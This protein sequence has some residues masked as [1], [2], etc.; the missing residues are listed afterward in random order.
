MSSAASA[1]APDHAPHARTGLLLA[2]LSA[3]GACYSLLQ[4]LVAPALPT[5]QHDLGVSTTA[6]AWIFTAYLLS[7]SI[8]TPIA[9]RLG[10]MFGK[11]KVFIVAVAALGVGSLIAA[12]SSSLGPMIAGR[13]IQ[14]IGGAVFPLS[15]AI[16]R[17]EFPR[18]KVAGGIAI[19]SAIL[20]IGGGLGIVLSGPIL[21]VLSYHWL[22]WIP[23][24]V[25]CLA[26]VAVI[27]VVPESKHRSGGTVNWLGAALLSGWL[28]CLLLGVSQGRTW[29]WASGR[30]IGLFVA[31]AV[32]AATWIK[33]E[34]RS[35]VPLVDMR[36]MRRR[37]V[38]TTNLATMLIGFGMFASFLLVPQFVEIPTSTGYGFGASVTQAGLFLVPTT[39]AMLIVSPF[40]GRITNRFGS[41]VPLVTGAVVSCAAFFLL[42]LA[43]NQRWEIYVGTTLMGIGIGFAFASMAN[44]I[45]EAVPREQTGVASGMNTIMRSI[46]SSL[47][48]QTSAT[49]IAANL[50]VGGLPAERGFT[51]AF[52]VCAGVLVVG[53]SAAA[54]VPSRAARAQA[55]TAASAGS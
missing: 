14:G 39:I 49:L 13:A 1:A 43:H 55:A 31:A 28:V 54:L 40:T 26:V 19:T 47:G 17:D 4:S 5:I 27:L 8:V 25:I 48:S 42:A 52:A 36:M 16:I 32:L 21:S 2:T 41:K 15:Y 24:F 22:F 46:G 33:V 3:A 53:S 11:K 45:V 50:L 30:T 18:H 35:P 6:V 10:D 29:G 37:A 12:L 51:L 7:A 20:G 23:F 38:W 9:G 34:D 44:L